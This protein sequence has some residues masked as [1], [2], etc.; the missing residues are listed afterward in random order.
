MSKLFVPTPKSVVHFVL[1]YFGEGSSCSSSSC[2]RGKTK[3]NPCPT[4]TG[5]MSLDWSLTIFLQYISL[6]FI[7]LFILA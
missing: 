1:V 2:D 3:S 7:L 4:W 6:N 5:L